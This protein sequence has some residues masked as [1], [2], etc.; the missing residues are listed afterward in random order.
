MQKLTKQAIALTLAILMLTSL[1]IPALA[2]RHP[3]TDV[4]DGR[5]YS[6]AVQFVYEHNIMGGVGN[7]QFNPRGHLT[8]AQVTALLFRVHNERAADERDDHDSNFADVNNE[9]FAPY[10]T[11]AFNNGIVTGTSA[12][13]FHP[14]GNITRQEFAT[15]VYRYAMEMTRFRDPGVPPWRWFEI[16]DS[17]Q[18]APWAYSALRWMNLR[19]IVTGTSE[20]TINPTG[21]ATRAE[22]AVMMMR[23]VRQLANPQLCSGCGDFRLPRLWRP[24]EGPFDSAVSVA[25]TYCASIKDNR[26]W[27]PEDFYAIDGILYIRDVRRLSDR[28]WELIQAGRVDETLVNWSQFRRIM[29]I[30]LDQNC[31]ENVIKVMR[32]LQQYEFIHTASPNFISYPNFISFPCI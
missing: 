9:W 14:H 1:A 3:F 16:T 23:F 15:M 32:Q 29:L 26:D 13:T 19:E 6:D 31:K 22:A 24:D 4:P 10:V 28:E 5:W 2:T 11:W 30:R 25:L 8:R 21:T 27:T 17:G 12:T 18:I 7:N 20:T